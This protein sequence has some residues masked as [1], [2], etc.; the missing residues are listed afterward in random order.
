MEWK[1]LH[2]TEDLPIE[3]LT[4]TQSIYIELVQKLPISAFALTAASQ[5]T[6][7]EETRELLAS[8][9][10]TTKI[11]EWVSTVV[12]EHSAMALLKMARNEQR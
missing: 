1:E 3:A 8:L 11:A 4:T 5:C 2:E 6:S 9:N 12:D 10:R 7:P